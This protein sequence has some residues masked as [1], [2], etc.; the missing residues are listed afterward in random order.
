M[1]QKLA[2]AKTAK[3]TILGGVVWWWKNRKNK[4][5]ATTKEGEQ[6]KASDGSHA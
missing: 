3:E 4:K 6:A 5:Q 2:E 1:R